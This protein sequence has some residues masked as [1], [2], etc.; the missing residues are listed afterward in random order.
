MVIWYI[1]K[2]YILLQCI[3]M[4]YMLILAWLILLLW[5][6]MMYN[7]PDNVLS[8]LYL[9]MSLKKESSNFGPQGWPV[10]LHSG[11]GLRA[12]DCRPQGTSALGKERGNTNGMCLMGLYNGICCRWDWMDNNYWDISVFILFPWDILSIT[13]NG[14][15]T[16][17][18]DHTGRNNTKQTLWQHEWKSFLGIWA[19]EIGQQKTPKNAL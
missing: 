3:F 6:M 4:S 19:P 15:A 13:S 11:P 2:S 18:L 1:A 10:H 5:I 12:S 8:C 7:P 17:F 16:Y 14:I 9:S